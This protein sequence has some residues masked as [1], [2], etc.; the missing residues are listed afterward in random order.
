MCDGECDN[1]T[2]PKYNHLIYTPGGV[3]LSTNTLSM[4]AIYPSTNWE[5]FNCHN[6]YGTKYTELIYNAL[7]QS[8]QRPL[9]LAS[10]TFASS[11][12][13]AGHWAGNNQGDWDSL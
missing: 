1:P 8:N 3:N 4:D 7:A 9:L 2:S 10:S 13:Y 6:V 5:E 11:G 12:I